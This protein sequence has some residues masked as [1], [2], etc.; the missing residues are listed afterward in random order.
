MTRVAV[1]VEGWSAEAAIAF[2]LA[3]R[4]FASG[5]TLS[6]S[7]E[8]A[9]GK[10]D[11]EVMTL[12]PEPGEEVVLVVDGTDEKE[13][14]DSLLAKLLSVIERSEH[15]HRIV[16]GQGMAGRRTSRTD[17][18]QPTSR[19]VCEREVVVLD[20]I[21]EVAPARAHRKKHANG[22]QAQKSTRKSKPRKRKK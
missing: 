17:H 22:P 4:R 1:A 11:I 21:E 16:L 8:T 10:D 20:T 7:G 14:F 12:G 6:T 13:A 2:A 19:R 3:A 5:V 9:N 15:A 18:V